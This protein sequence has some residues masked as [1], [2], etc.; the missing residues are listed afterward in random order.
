[1]F[2]YIRFR[3][4]LHMLQREQRSVERANEIARKAVEEKK[5]SASEIAEFNTLSMGNYFHYEEE[6]HRLHS[7]YL[8]GRA[9][10][11]LIPVPELGD[12]VMWEQSERTGYIYLSV[13]GINKV[14][15]DIRAEQKARVELFLLFVLGLVGVL[16]ALIGL[17][18]ILVSK[19]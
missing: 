12:K 15:T 5:A 1:V 18:S 11:L 13:R 10:R 3:W 16:G 4:Q 8:T 14:R 7:Q 19:R 9:S 17:V 6:T 2:R